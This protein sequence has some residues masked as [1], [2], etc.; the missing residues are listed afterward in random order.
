MSRGAVNF[1]IDFCGIPCI[2]NRVVQKVSPYW[3][4]RV[5]SI[6]HRYKQFLQAIPQ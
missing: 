6:V 3:N 4:S 1:A 2:K 5:L